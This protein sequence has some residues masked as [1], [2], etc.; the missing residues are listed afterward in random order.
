MG[1]LNFN[2]VLAMIAASTPDG[3]WNLLQAWL[4][5]SPKWRKQVDQWATQSPDQVIAEL[6]IWIA[7]T[8]GVGA[9]V[10]VNDGMRAKIKSAI[11]NLQSRYRERLAADGNNQ[12][13]KE[14]KNVRRKRVPTRSA[15]RA[16]KDRD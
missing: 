12:I 10:L 1:A 7:E 6:E 13:E 5:K 8:Y 4:R 11:E 9:M 15:K 3:R 2:T 16:S 14:I